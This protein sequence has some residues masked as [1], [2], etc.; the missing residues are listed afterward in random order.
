MRAMTKSQLAK[1]AGVSRWTLQR[2]LRDPY[3]REKLA[4]FQLTTKQQLLPPGAVQIIAE[5]YAIEID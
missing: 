1:A 5:H 2:W 3:I 4:P